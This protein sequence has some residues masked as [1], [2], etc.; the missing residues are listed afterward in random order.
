MKYRAVCPSC[1]HKFGRLWYFKV[2]PEY[3]HG[4]PGCGARLKSESRSEWGFSA[5]FGTPVVVAFVLWRFWG[6]SAWYIALAVVVMLLTGPAF[7]PYTTKFELKDEQ[8]KQDT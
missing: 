1:G 7:F 8:K 3:G 5:V 6:V 4:C 2:V